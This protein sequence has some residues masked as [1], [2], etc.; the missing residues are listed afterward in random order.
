MAKIEKIFLRVN[1]DLKE[2]WQAAVDETK[3]PQNQVGK[4]LVEFF[5]SLTRHEKADLLAGNLR[6]PDVSDGIGLLS[7]WEDL[8]SSDQEFVYEQIVK[9]MKS[10]GTLPS[11][12]ATHEKKPARPPLNFPGMSTA[13]EMLNSEAA[14]HPQGGDDP[15]KAQRRKKPK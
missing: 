8:P 7:A 4:A 14:S 1:L 5:L 15:H 13:Q 11:S 3:A 12:S 9:Q 2:R 6:I 10:D